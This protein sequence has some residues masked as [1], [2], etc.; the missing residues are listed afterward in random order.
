MVGLRAQMSSWIPRHEA[1]VIRQYCGEHR[2]I[3]CFRIARQNTNYIKR[4]KRDA[5]TLA[6]VPKAT[7]FMYAVAAA[8]NTTAPSRTN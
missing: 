5:D 3:P 6:V 8:T 1:V 2:Q 4:Y 7:R